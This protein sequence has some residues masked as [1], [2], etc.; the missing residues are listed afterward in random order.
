LIDQRVETQVAAPAVTAA[1][2]YTQTAVATEQ[3]R[4][5]VRTPVPGGPLLLGQPIE[6]AI[7]LFGRPAAGSRPPGTYTFLPCARG[8]TRWSVLVQQGLVISISRQLCAGERPPAHWLQDLGAHLP[9][10]TIFL[11]QAGPEHGTILRFYTSPALQAAQFVGK[12]GYG[13]PG[14][15][16]GG[17]PAGTLFAS[18]HL[19]A[20]GS[21]DHWTV[22]IGGCWRLH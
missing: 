6:E 2:A 16:G 9:S 15:N 10:G 17:D 22:S 3:A 7:A 8:G 13:V 20:D 5:S 14:C 12:V 4:R 1:A 19:H 11:G 21:L 18:I